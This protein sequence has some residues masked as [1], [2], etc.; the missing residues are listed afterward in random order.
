V[1]NSGDWAVRKMA[2]DVIYTMGA[3]LKDSVKEFKAEIVDVLNQCRYDKIKPVR[4]AAAEALT[5]YKEIKVGAPP[6]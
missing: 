2:I 3:I 1:A 6:Q 4:D 5:A